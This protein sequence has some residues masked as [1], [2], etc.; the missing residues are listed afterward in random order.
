MGSVKRP[1]E[2]TVKKGAVKKVGVKV[3][4]KKNVSIVAKLKK[5]VEHAMKRSV[6]PTLK[7]PLDPNI[8]RGATNDKTAPLVTIK[9]MKRSDTKLLSIIEGMTAE[10]A[11]RLRS[12][13]LGTKGDGAATS[14]LSKDTRA[15]QI[16]EGQTAEEAELSRMARLDDADET[17][18]DM[19]RSLV[20]QRKAKEA[21]ICYHAN[22]RWNDRR[23]G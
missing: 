9:Q 17:A 11:E 4:V 23:G 8:V 15:V 16:A 13:R 5:P 20:K 3:G 18:L 6:E 2:P 14:I 12:A 21:M 19:K 10:E 22:V 7:R 1:I